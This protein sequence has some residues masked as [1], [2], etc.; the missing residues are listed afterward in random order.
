[1]KLNFDHFGSENPGGKPLII[2]HGLFGSASNFRSLARA[3]AEYYSVYCLDLR[4]HGASPHDEDVSLPAMAHD[5]L[6]FMMEQNIPSASIMGHSLGGKVAMQLALNHPEKIDKLI[7]GDIAPVKYPHHHSRIFEGLRAVPLDQISSRKEAGLILKDYVEEAGVRL[8]LLTNLVRA[9]AGGFRWRVNIEALEKNY[10]HIA[11]A[12]EGRPFHGPTLFIRGQLS[13]YITDENRPG[14]ER[15]FPNADMATIAEAGHWL[16]AEKPQ[17]FST[18]L[19][20]FL[21]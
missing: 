7:L 17:E 3:Y 10:D 4:N 16:H 8:F 9:E 1:M 18:L 20:D 13:H 2:V 6:D 15:L 21:A 11:A 19:L 12:P 5:L 14:L